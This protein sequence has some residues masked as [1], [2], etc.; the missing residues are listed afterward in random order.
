MYINTAV[1]CEVKQRYLVVGGE[2]G[3][4]VFGHDFEEK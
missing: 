4:S 1:C 2:G 3:A